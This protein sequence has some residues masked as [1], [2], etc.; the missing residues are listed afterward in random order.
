[1]LETHSCLQST[2]NRQGYFGDSI[3]IVYGIHVYDRE[4]LIRIQLITLIQIFN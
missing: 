4:M 3:I 2:K 1:M